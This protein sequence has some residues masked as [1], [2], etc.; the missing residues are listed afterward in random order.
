MMVDKFDNN[1]KPGDL[2]IQIK[3][4]TKPL[5]IVTGQGK[6]KVRD[7]Q[8]IWLNEYILKGIKEGRI[9]KPAIYSWSGIQIVKYDINLVP[10]ETRDNYYDFLKILNIERPI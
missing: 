4:W 7:I 5:F 3:G 6:G 10:K 2:V 9:E 8:T 1:L